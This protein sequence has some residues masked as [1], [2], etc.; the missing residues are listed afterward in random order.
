MKNKKMSFVILKNE[1][2]S[3]IKDEV[4][5][6]LDLLIIPMIMMIFEKT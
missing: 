1:F 5:N 2:S 3:L 4:H 6:F